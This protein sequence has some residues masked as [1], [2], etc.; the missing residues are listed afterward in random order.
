MTKTALMNG[1]RELT[2][3]IHGL[4]WVQI[5]KIVRIL[6]IKYKYPMPKFYNISNPANVR[7]TLHNH[8]K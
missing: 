3:M 6:F 1:N 5:F 2:E 8:A 4:I 7:Y